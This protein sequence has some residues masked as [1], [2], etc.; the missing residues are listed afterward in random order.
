MDKVRP[1]AMN[2][3]SN[4][5]LTDKDHPLPDVSYLTEYKLRDISISAREAS[6][7]IKGLDSTKATGMDKICLQSWQKEMFSKPKEGCL[8]CASCSRMQV[9]PRPRYYIPRSASLESLVNF[10]KLS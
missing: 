8:V 1:F 3:A 4:S 10:L 9:K 6:R 7:F 2:F 5:R